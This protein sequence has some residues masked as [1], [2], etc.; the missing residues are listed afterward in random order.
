MIIIKT[1]Q[2]DIS[3]K[4]YPEKTPE[5][6]ANF[7]EYVREGFYNNTIFHRVIADFMIQCGGYDPE[8]NTKKTRKPIQNEA[9]N[10][11]S[12]LR[13]TV[14]MARRPDAHSA[15]SQFF[16]NVVDNTYLDYKAPIDECYGYC[17]FGEVVEGM[18]VVDKISKVKTGTYQL[19]RDMPVEKVTISEIIEVED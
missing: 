8:L 4:L 7:L 3:V 9:K 1:S 14:A 12:N 10:G 2:G 18:D 6:V 17:A 15:T 19:F 11:L 5:T 13:G 16:I